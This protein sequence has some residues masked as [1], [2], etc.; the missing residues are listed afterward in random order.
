MTL[1]PPDGTTIS[2]ATTWDVGTLAA[3]QTARKV[4]EARADTLAAGPEIVWK[5]LSTTAT[6]DLRPAADADGAS[7]GPKVIPPG[8]SFDTARYGDR[9]FPVVPVDYA[10][11]KHDG[12]PQRRAGSRQKINAPGN[13]GSTFNLYQEMSYG[14]LFPHGDGARRRAS[15]RRTATYAAGL[16]LHDSPAPQPDLPRRRRL[17]DAPGTSST[18]DAHQGRLVPAARRRPT[19]TATTATARR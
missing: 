13:P 6:A 2:G 1:T 4:V 8:G 15:R 17:N 18:R 16:R 10:D 5:N 9:P 19:T 7:H 14:Q 3:G 11:R 12:D